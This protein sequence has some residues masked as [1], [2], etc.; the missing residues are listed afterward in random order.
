MATIRPAR[1]EDC[2]TL[3]GLIRDLAIYEELEH[4]ARAT[5]DDLRRDLFGPRVH[6]E[7]LLAEEGS[8]P[9]GFALF[10]HNYS[11]FRGRPGLYLEDLFV[12]PSHR[13]KGLGKRLLARLAKIAVGRGCARF[14]WS[15]LDWNEPSIGFYRA[16]GALPMDEWTTYRVDGLALARLAELDFP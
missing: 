16:L 6:A 11:T 15:V 13:G 2:E 14:E 7:A 4:E 10:F 5:A 1:A 3:A 12:R 9:V 8:E